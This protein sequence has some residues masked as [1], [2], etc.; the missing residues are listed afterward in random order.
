MQPTA[1]SLQ[2]TA[3]TMYTQCATR[4]VDGVVDGVVD[5]V[6]VNVAGQSLNVVVITLAEKRGRCDPSSC[7]GVC[8][9]AS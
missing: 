4:S 2:H 7:V 5:V 9:C 1:H 3:Y 6:G 8:M